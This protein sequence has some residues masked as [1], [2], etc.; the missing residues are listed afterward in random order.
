MMDGFRGG[1][2]NRGSRLNLGLERCDGGVHWLKK[3]VF[4]SW[5]EG[6][7]DFRLMVQSMGADESTST[8]LQLSLS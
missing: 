4:C 8:C 5:G 2:S 7:F 3:A 1:R 6:V